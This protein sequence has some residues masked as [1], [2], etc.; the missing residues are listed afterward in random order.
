MDS[1]D[2]DRRSPRSR[3]PGRGAAAAHPN[4]GSN[5]RHAASGARPAPAPRVGGPPAAAE[6]TTTVQYGLVVRAP[7][8]P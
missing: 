4:N 5:G 3:M 8:D 1:R 7:A 6:H 2:D